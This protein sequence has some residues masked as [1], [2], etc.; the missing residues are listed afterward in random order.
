MTS[1]V[2]AHRIVTSC[3]FSC[4]DTL[5]AHSIVALDNLTYGGEAMLEAAV[6]VDGYNEFNEDA[7]I[8]G[9]VENFEDPHGMTLSWC[10]TIPGAY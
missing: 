8:P 6:M 7:E 4:S 2:S 1:A 10:K 3:G 9:R 5:R